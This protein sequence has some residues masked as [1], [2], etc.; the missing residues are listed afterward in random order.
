MH[1]ELFHI[2]IIDHPVKSY[3]A[4]LTLGFLTGVWLSIRRA[5][6]LKCDPDLVLNLGFIC[7]VCGVAGARLFYVL[8]YWETSFAN[9]PVPLW[10]ALNCTA[11]GL[12]YYGGLIGA[13]VGCVGY[14]L[15][16][17]ASLRLYLDILTPAAAW[18]LAFGRM[19]CL[20][21]GCCWGGLAPVDAHG[22][23][24][25][26]WAITF[27]HH[28][29]PQVRQWE[30]RQLTLPAELMVTDPRTSMPRLVPLEGLEISPEKRAQLD[31]QAKEAR[32]RVEEL[33]K[34]GVRSSEL[35]AAEAR[36][37]AAETRRD[38]RGLLAIEEARKYP[39]RQF[40][41][42]D[43]RMT[44]TE[45]ADLA[46]QYRSHPVHPSQIYGIVNALLLSWL[47]LE[48]LYRRKRHGVVFAWLCIIYPITRIILEIV[49]VDNPHD[50]AGLTISQAVSV[51]MFLFGVAL[52][53][54]L[55]RLPE[56]S[57]LAVPYMP[58][59]DEK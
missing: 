50:S 33:K 51:G 17:R 46:H 16:K 44:A 23:A 58:P 34:K 56:R 39:S 52:L 55:R 1:P 5:E 32:E 28:S 2:P 6:R 22:H 7:L 19:G 54:Y 12:E 13:M 20:L 37:R 18:G 21:N 59:P 31:R 29:S 48:V 3:G 10:S 25:L 49:R 35:E 8:H 43:A 4:M 15:I 36:Y 45:L 53:L 11:G 38:A 14:I 9:Q 47:L 26:P 41:S 27:P 24:A 42:G 40:A 30:N 57:P